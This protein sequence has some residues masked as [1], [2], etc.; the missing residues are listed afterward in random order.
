MTFKL[1]KDFIMAVSKLLS[2]LSQRYLAS[3]QI[4]GGSCANTLLMTDRKNHDIEVH[5][6]VYELHFASD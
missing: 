1:H 5:I 4:S 2:S 6:V 3:S